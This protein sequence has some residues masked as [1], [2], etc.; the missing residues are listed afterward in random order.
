[1][2]ISHRTS[3]FFVVKGVHAMYY[4]GVQCSVVVVCIYPTG[5]N[6]VSYA[7]LDLEVRNYP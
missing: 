3:S 7:N 6:Y 5:I 4:M 1:M 2:R